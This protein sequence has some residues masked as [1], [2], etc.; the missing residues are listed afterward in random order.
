M[1]LSLSPK[2]VEKLVWVPVISFCKIFIPSYASDALLCRNWLF[3]PPN[4]LTSHIT[5]LLLHL[6]VAVFFSSLILW[7]CSSA[8]EYWP[9]FGDIQNRKVKKNSYAPF[10][11]AVS[12][13]NFWQMLLNIFVFFGLIA[14]QK[15][16]FMTE[17]SLLKKSS[18]WRKFAHRKHFTGI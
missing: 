14:F 8:E 7:C 3:S 12:C 5:L 17:Y 10:H 4:R 1:K 9:K 16:E 11:V 6:D 15:W 13:G 18:K 2:L